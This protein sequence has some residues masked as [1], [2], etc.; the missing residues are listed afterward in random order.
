MASSSQ[1]TSIFFRG[2]KQPIRFKLV[3]FMSF[4]PWAGLLVQ[5]YR[6]YVQPPGESQWMVFFTC[7]RFKA[8]I[9]LHASQASLVRRL[10]VSTEGRCL[11]FGDF[12]G[13]AWFS[14]RNGRMTGCWEEHVAIAAH[15]FGFSEERRIPARPS[16]GG[17]EESG[18]L[19]QWL[20][21]VVMATRQGVERG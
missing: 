13:F 18:G 19:P 4:S 11:L 14:D 8:W 10:V 9:Y 16:P 3:H 7:L 17:P 5:T 2:L 20:P 12:V 6:K 1:L 21:Q 15:D